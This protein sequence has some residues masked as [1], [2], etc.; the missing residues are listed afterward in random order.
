MMIPILGPVRSWWE[1]S[2]ERFLSILKKLMPRGGNSFDKTIMLRYNKREKYRMNAAYSDIKHDNNIVKLKNPLDQIFDNEII[3]KENKLIQ[4]E[5]EKIELEDLLNTCIDYTFSIDFNE[6]CTL[7]NSVIKRLKISYDMDQNNTKKISFQKWILDILESPKS[8]FQFS[9][10]QRKHADLL[11]LSDL[12]IVSELGV[13]KIYRC[14]FDSIQTALSTHLMITTKAIVNGTEMVGR[15]FEYR[16]IRGND[17]LNP[18]NILRN[19]W[20]H[21]KQ[22]N[23][24]FFYTASQTNKKDRQFG[25]LNFFFRVRWPGDYVL[26]NVA[27]A[28]STNRIH[29]ICKRVSGVIDKTGYLEVLIANNDSSFSKKLCNFVVV[30][31]ILSTRV[32]ILPLDQLN[33]PMPHLIRRTDKVN[34]RE[35]STERDPSQI[36][37]LVMFPLQPYRCYMKFTIDQSELGENPVDSD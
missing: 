13:N 2:G 17:N 37:K 11:L 33:K 19:T 32:A 8:S 24:W 3:L 5:L 26:D 29:N 6:V 1:Y 28:S 9:L 31:N 12:H 36:F 25:Q 16:E 20:Y 18:L 30:R 22:Y 34:K 14:D 4:K 27:L 23:S 21:K 35:F 15:G 10:I 7:Q